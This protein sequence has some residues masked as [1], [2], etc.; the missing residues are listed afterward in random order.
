MVRRNGEF[1]ALECYLLHF[2]SATQEDWAKLLDIAQSSY[3]LQ[4]SEATGKSPFD[5]ATGQQPTTLHSMVIPRN[6]T[7]SPKAQKMAKMWEDHADFA[8]A[9][10]EK[11]RK[12]MKKWADEKRHPLE[13]KVGDR[14][15]VTFPTIQSLLE[16]AQ[17]TSSEIRGS[18][19]SHRQSR[20]GIIQT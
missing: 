11:S 3:N 20:Q 19:R 7:R 10:L 2:V 1:F 18:V 4:R 5:F 13:F 17:G 16:Y 12:R 14:V 8:W 9:C 15:L 6:E